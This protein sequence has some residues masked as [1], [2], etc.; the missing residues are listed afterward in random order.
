MV[1]VHV[2]QDHEF[3]RSHAVLVQE[4]FCGRGVGVPCVNQTVFFISGGIYVFQQD[5]KTV[6]LGERGGNIRCQPVLFGTGNL[7]RRNDSL[8]ML[9]R[10]CKDEADHQKKGDDPAHIFRHMFS[11]E[12]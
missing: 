6:P 5:A 12:A 2:C 7:F 10:H 9:C 4:S 11:F 3:Q 8:H 1:L